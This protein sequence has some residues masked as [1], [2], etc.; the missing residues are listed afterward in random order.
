MTFS[1][2][3]PSAPIHDGADRRLAACQ[4]ELRERSAMLAR[5]GMSVADATSRLSARIAWEFDGAS[6]RPEGLSDAAIAGLV[7]EV[8]ASKR[9]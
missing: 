9:F 3:Q 2:Q 5:L 7:A 8:Y 4:R 1:W 6:G